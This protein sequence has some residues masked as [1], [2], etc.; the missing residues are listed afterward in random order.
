MREDSGKGWQLYSVWMSS[1][2]ANAICR[3]V[4]SGTQ[5]AS[6]RLAT[7]RLIGWRAV[8]ASIALCLAGSAALAQT[9]NTLVNFDGT[10]GAYPYATV[11]QGTDGNLYGTSYAGGAHGSGE[12]LEMESNGV[13]TTL[14]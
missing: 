5:P 8:C 2:T 6:R 1:V 12:V 10:D 13:L 7:S 3:S 4:K 9:F 14:Y 11:V